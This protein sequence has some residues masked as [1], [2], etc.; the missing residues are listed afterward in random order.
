DGQPPLPHPLPTRRS[1]DLTSVLR[2]CRYMPSP[3]APS[4]STI[5]ATATA[6]LCCLSPETMYSA[7]DGGLEDVASDDTGAAFPA[8]PRVE[9][10]SEEHTSELESRVDIVCR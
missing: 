2:A 5:R 4:A 8:A 1:S 9:R 7:L 3:T 6:S 10:R